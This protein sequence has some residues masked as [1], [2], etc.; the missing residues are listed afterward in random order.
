MADKD[1]VVG[2][3]L[4]AEF[5]SGTQTY[6]IIMTPDGITTEGRNVPATIYRRQISAMKPRR[7]WKTYSLPKLP[8]DVAGQFQTLEKALASDQSLS[9]LGY[10]ENTFSRMDAYNYELYKQ[11]IIVEVSQ[12]DLDDIRVAKT[13]Y[14]ILGRITRVRKALGFGE[15]LFA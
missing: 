7:A 4:Y 3:A 5:R 13:P 10:V 1:K 8:M 15:K 12:A 11:P 6:Q 14:K 9:R 2:K